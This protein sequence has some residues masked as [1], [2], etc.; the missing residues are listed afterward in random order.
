M[1]MRFLLTDPS[2]KAIIERFLVENIPELHARY[3]I[4]PSTLVPVIF[5]D[6]QTT[7]SEAR[8]GL[9]KHWQSSTGMKPMYNA[10]SESVADK[11]IFK[12]DF[13]ES[14]CL[15]LADGFYEWK[16]EGKE[17]KPY[18]RFLQPQQIFAFAGIYGVRDGERQC[19]MITTNSNDLV[20]QL[21]NRMPAILPIGHE[22]DYLNATPKEAK[23]ML[24]PYPS[25]MMQMYEVSQELNSSRLD[26]AYLITPVKSKTLMDY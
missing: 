19:C 22:K 24:K 13:E 12:K 4:A 20:G 26:E 5:G 17:K 16:H 2:R 21:H 23:E 8:W 25:N 7:L 15:M 3:N 11:P 6:G 9:M 18:R 14:R 1:C 10:R